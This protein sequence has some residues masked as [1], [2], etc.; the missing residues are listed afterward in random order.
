MLVHASKFNIPALVAKSIG[1]CEVIGADGIAIC[2][3]DGKKK[4]ILIYDFNV[5]N[6]QKLQL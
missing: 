5:K 2:S 4:T 6:T 3:L 1:T